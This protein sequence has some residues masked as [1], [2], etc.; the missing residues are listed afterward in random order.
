MDSWSEIIDQTWPVALAAR[1]PT[2]RFLALGERLTFS[3]AHTNGNGVHCPNFFGYIVK[4]SLPVLS[5]SLAL[6]GSLFSLA[7]GPPKTETTNRHET[8]RIS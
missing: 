7:G 1:G 6:S 5:P 3:G 8:Q 2:A 4:H